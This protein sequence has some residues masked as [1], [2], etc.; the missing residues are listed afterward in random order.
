MNTEQDD[1]IQRGG[2]L[3][4]GEGQVFL[5]V[6]GSRGKG[7]KGLDPGEASVEE[8][9]SEECSGSGGEE[10][11]NGGEAEETKDKKK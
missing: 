7:D 9:C 11:E 6:K 5:W 8:E 10:L 4:V 1:G 3:R 2:L